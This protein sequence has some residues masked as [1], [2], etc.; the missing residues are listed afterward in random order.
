[1][2]ASA[3]VYF[4]L[5]LA[6]A[7]HTDALHFSGSPQAL[8]LQSAIHIVRTCVA[9]RLVDIAR[10]LDRPAVIVVA[11]AQAAYTNT[12]NCVTPFQAPAANRAIAGENATPC[13]AGPQ[14]GRSDEEGA[15]RASPHHFFRRDIGWS[16]KIP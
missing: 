11:R 9:K 10:F 7:S 6:A 2:T 16:A 3:G 13:A 5:R 15:E 12:I 14:Q 1:M 4:R 8:V